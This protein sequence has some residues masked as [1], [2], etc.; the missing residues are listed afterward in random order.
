M[1][2][3]PRPG[4]EY[5]HHLQD[6]ILWEPEGAGGRTLTPGGFQCVLA[7]GETE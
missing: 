4:L 2:D 6:S 7:A 1:W 5:S 3:L